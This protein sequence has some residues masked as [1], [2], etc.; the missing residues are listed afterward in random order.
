MQFQVVEKEDSLMIH[1]LKNIVWHDLQIKWWPLLPARVP[2][3]DMK[4]DDSYDVTL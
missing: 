1:L 2:K 4:G 3:I